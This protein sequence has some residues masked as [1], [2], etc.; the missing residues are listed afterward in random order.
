MTFLL[1]AIFVPMSTRVPQENE[2]M[3]MHREGGLRNWRVTGMKC[4]LADNKGT[5]EAV[6]CQ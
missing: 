5:P 2:E 4:S 6:K 1:I 3:D